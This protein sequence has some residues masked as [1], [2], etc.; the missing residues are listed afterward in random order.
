MQTLTGPEWTLAITTLAVLAGMGIAACLHILRNHPWTARLTGGQPTGVN[1]LL[2]LVGLAWLGLFGLTVWAAYLGIWQAIHP[3]TDTTGSGQTPFGLGALLAALLGAPF[4]IWAT[5]IKQTTLNFQKEGHIT[6]RISKAVEQLGAEKKVDRIG[7]PVT[8][9]TGGSQIV[10]QHVADP[11]A[12]EPPKRSRVIRRYQDQTVEPSGEVFDG[13]HV[14]LQRWKTKRTVIEWQ[15]APISVAGDEWRDAVGA[16]QVFS[17]SLPNI[18]VRIGAILSLERIAQDSCA[19]D[20]GRDHVRVLEILCAYVRNNAP[21]IQANHG[22]LTDFDSQS[23]LHQKVEAASRVHKWVSTLP[24][25]RADIDIAIRVIGGRTKAQRKIEAKHVHWDAK[26]YVPDLSLTNL[27]N[28]NLEGL[29]FTG[30]NFYQSRM[31]GAFCQKATFSNCNFIEARLTGISGRSAI[32][33]RAY[34]ASADFSE[35]ILDDADFSLS[36]FSHTHFVSSQLI[37]AHFNFHPT[38]NPRS[39]PV[40]RIFLLDCNLSEAWL[41]GYLGSAVIIKFVKVHEE[42]A[43]YF[44]Q[45]ACLRNASTALR[46]IRDSG[47][48]KPSVIPNGLLQFMFGDASVDLGSS[49]PPPHWP[50]TILDDANYQSELQRWRANPEEYLPLSGPKSLSR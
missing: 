43:K 32:F 34:L 46:S 20:R 19:Y 30:T 49:P 26:S 28:A 25:P 8:I 5:V 11:D 39:I 16:W 35:A 17:E 36:H 31:E 7:R 45:K 1:T 2:V 23:D 27:Q 24:Y 21:A 4:V 22:P 40:N 6:D 12:W 9:L 41:E 37:N 48:A 33:E 13:L 44:I 50:T 15:G 38:E 42:K 10:T 18:E 14:E 29:D 3:D 47:E